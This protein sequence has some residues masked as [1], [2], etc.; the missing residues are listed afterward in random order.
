MT[1]LPKYIAIR[2]LE[3]ACIELSSEKHPHYTNIV[4]APLGIR[5]AHDITAKVERIAKRRCIEAG[6][7]VADCPRVVDYTLPDDQQTGP[8]LEKW[9]V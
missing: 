6:E 8:G 4:T 3:Q 9:N 1:G 7:A 2:D 5:L